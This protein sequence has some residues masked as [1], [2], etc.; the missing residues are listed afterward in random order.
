MRALARTGRVRLWIGAF[1]MA[2][3]LTTLAFN[4]RDPPRRTTLPTLVIALC[5]GVRALLL[6]S[7][8]QFQDD[9]L[10]YG[11]RDGLII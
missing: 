5:G 3:R 10:A 8:G 6:D 11:R 7:E 1:L 9:S 2:F 4:S